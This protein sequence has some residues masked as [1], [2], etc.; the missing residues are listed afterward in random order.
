[1]RLYRTEVS[2]SVPAALCKRGRSRLSAPDS[3]P[4][5]ARA[6]AGLASSTARSRG[7][8][9]GGT[10][11]GG[12]AGPARRDSGPGRRRGGRG[13]APSCRGHPRPGRA[14]RPL[15]A[16]RG[17]AGEGGARE[18]ALARPV[19]P[20]RSRARPVSF[21]VFLHCSQFPP[22]SPNVISRLALVAP[23]TFP[24]STPVPP[25]LRAHSGGF[26]MR[27]IFTVPSNPNQS[28][29]QLRALPAS[30]TNLAFPLHSQHHSWLPLRA[31]MPF[32]CFQYRFLAI[33]SAPSATPTT[34][35]PVPGSPPALPVPSQRTQ[36]YS[37]ASPYAFP[38][39]P[40]SLPAVLPV[41]CTG[42]PQC[43]QPVPRHGQVSRLPPP[44]AGT[45]RSGSRAR[46]G[47][48][49]TGSG[50]GRRRAR[51]PRVTCAPP[52]P[53]GAIRAARAG[54][55]PGRYRAG[56]RARARSGEGRGE[57]RGGGPGPARR[58]KPWAA[59]A[60]GRAQRAGAGAGELSRQRSPLRLPSA[61][62]QWR[63]RQRAC[64]AAGRRAAAAA[65]STWHSRGTA[66]SAGPASR[67]VRRGER[68]VLH[69]AS[70]EASQGARRHRRAPGG[71][72]LSR[73]PAMDCSL[74]RTLVSRYVSTAG[75]APPRARG[76]A[77]AVAPG[78]LEGLGQELGG[79]VTDPAAGEP[80]GRRT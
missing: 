50:H 46:D 58:I 44:G 48:G 49:G 13:S 15:P 27:S 57:R 45:G 79:P 70:E 25:G 71:A 73:P 30:F 6:G 52:G 39:R 8:A 5:C 67:R 42:S 7:W 78:S 69:V 9:G 32:Q 53:P 61:G 1:M 3:A 36:C 26:G 33:L 31:L 4:C 17:G 34:P 29:L 75:A 28:I 60:A 76:A 66:T 54:R 21:I 55:G 20:Q 35:V 77:P 19:A 23:A 41:Q 72:V 16:A 22:G 11:E 2:K 59:R 68:G 47:T 37:L 18:H 65:A 80:R 56:P 38:S 74:L 63:Q 51:P 40:V 64:G 14:R 62:L 12:S 10:L 24:G 43:S